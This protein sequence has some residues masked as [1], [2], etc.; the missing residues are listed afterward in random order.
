MP[1][2]LSPMGHRLAV[3][4]A[5]ALLAAPAFAQPPPAPESPAM[6]PP[7]PP[8][9]VE[10]E[11]AF[12]TAEQDALQ[13][14][15]E[16][17][18]SVVPLQQGLL[19]QPREGGAV[20][21]EIAADGTVA[22]NGEPAA[23]EALRDLL[24]EERAALIERLA[25]LP[26]RR[27]L[28]VTGS[29]AAALPVEGG[30]EPPRPPQPPAPRHLRH[31]EHRR[32][33]VQV[34]VG[35]RLVIAPEETSEGAVV[36]GGPLEVRGRVEGDAVAIGGGITV[37]GEVTGD[38]AAVG[39]P[40]SLG[41]EAEVWGDAVSV[42]GTVRR[43]SG[44]VVHGQVVE[45]PFGSTINFPDW[46]D[47]NFWPPTKWPQGEVLFTPWRLV[48]KAMWRV[49]GIA[50]LALLACL[51]LL[52]APRPVERVQRA[53]AVEAWKAGLIGFL[54]QAL[55]L[56]TL[57]V[58]ILVLCISIIGIPLLL[59][60]PFAIMGLCLVAFVG[61]CGV[62]YQI[63]RF[64]ERRFGWDLTSPYLVITVGVVAIH[65][66]SLVGALLAWGPLWIFSIMFRTFGALIWY[67]AGTVGF[68]AALLTR[69]G[70]TDIAGGAAPEL[71]PAAGPPGGEAA[72]LPP[73]E[74]V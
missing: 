39:G 2:L 24:G 37:D 18:F 48:A 13:A 12:P 1:D 68:G 11:T 31:G 28:F 47:W 54:A 3:L 66:W 34:V 14:E 38:V 30:P 51:V 62:A 56:P 59:L 69:F 44:A 8:P 49:F 15:V 10:P 22:V 33:D 29:A 61:Y 67:V 42:G 27:Q 35:S 23:G 58:V 46:G 5:A 16:A 53:I 45:V 52:V 6:P 25:A 65:V 21:I 32:T 55:F 36:F 43:Q 4:A 20:A 40:V 73:A 7:S 9:S 72:G 50:V 57:L 17:R 63:G 64:I 26:D 71:P 70:T 60:V 19:L 41:P 74:G